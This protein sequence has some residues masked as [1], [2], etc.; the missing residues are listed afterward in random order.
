MKMAQVAHSV[1]QHD[2]ETQEGDGRGSEDEKMRK[3]LH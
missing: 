1:A 2:K 3:R